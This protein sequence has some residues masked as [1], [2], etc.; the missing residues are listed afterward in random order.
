MEII[1]FLEL[2]ISWRRV[3]ANPSGKDCVVEGRRQICC[4]ARMTVAFSGNPLSEEAQRDEHVNDL[5]FFKHNKNICGVFFFFSGRSHEKH[6]QHSS[7]L[8]LHAAR[9]LPQLHQVGGFGQ[10]HVCVQFYFKVKFT[11]KLNYVSSIGVCL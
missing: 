6:Q 8:P 3:M 9:P 10:S 5:F 7:A 11:L 2:R 4:A 1:A